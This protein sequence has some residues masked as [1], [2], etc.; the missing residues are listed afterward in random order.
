[1]KKSSSKE[2]LNSVAPESPT[3]GGKAQA[4]KGSQ[5]KVSYSSQYINRC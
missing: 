3:P 1:M 5:L 2:K 4:E